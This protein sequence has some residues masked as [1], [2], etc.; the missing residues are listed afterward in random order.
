LEFYPNEEQEFIAEIEVLIIKLAGEKHELE[1][2]SISVQE[3][4]EA[5]K[6]TLSAMLAVKKD[7]ESIL[8][9]IPSVKLK[10]VNDLQAQFDEFEAASKKVMVIP[11]G[12]LEVEVVPAKK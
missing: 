3:D 12:T 1:Q 4:L 8:D 10:L 7:L 6:N 9:A 11:T 2:V 5:S